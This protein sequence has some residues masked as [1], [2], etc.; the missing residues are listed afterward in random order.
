MTW[1]DGIL[2]ESRAETVRGA[3]TLRRLA[4]FV[5]RFLARLAL[6]VGF[7]G[8]TFYGGFVVHD[9]HETFGGPETGE[10][11]R[12]VAVVLYAFGLA[13]VFL[14]ALAM[15]VDRAER[16][17][18]R[19]KARAALL[20]LD[21]LF[22]AALVAMHRELA[23]RIDGGASRAAFFPLHESYLTVFAAQWL[24]S[25]GLLAVDSAGTTPD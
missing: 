19:G 3:S 8:F 24:A 11:S 10:I 21:A 13:A 12:R 4:T 17:G 25:L 2:D 6:A 22:L 9:L 7:G 5:L 15:A 16:R 20:V 14:H 1:D 18:W 23:A